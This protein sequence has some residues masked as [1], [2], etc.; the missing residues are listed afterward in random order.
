MANGG[1]GWGKGLLK[2]LNTHFNPSQKSL[3]VLEC[4]KWERQNIFISGKRECDSDKQLISPQPSS[5][6]SPPCYPLP[7]G[8]TKIIFFSN[9]RWNQLTESQPLIYLSFYISN[10]LFFCVSLNESINYSTINL[11]CCNIGLESWLCRS[12]G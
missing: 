11:G 7:L 9:F 3:E 5:L 12:F 1:G 2:L 4:R 6:I 8:Y 10:Y